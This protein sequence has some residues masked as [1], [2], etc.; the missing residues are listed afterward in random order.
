MKT[1]EKI[2]KLARSTTD[3]RLKMRYLAV[4]HYESNH[5]RTQIAKMLGVARRSVNVWIKTY[6]EQGLDALKSK[7]SPG[8]PI[9]LND[10][11]LVLLKQFITDNSVKR[12][13]GRL[14]AEDVRQ[15]IQMT[16]GVNYSLSNTYR[17]LHALEF[18]WITSRSRHPKQSME[19]QDA[20]KKLPV[21][22]DP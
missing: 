3:A 6:L 5:N 9:N 10:A 8:R 12:Q 2:K 15:Y 18:S 4:Y 19:A 22:N 11:Q 21:G 1:A 17:L 20:F 7:K 16:F 14:I 13:G